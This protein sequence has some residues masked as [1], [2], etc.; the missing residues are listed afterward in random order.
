MNVQDV[1]VQASARLK[2]VLTNEK[3]CSA[4]LRDDLDTVKV[5]AINN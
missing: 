4:R 3:E 1:A 5:S 2:H